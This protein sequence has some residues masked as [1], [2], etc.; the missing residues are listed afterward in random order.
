L[1]RA[2]PLAARL[3]ALATAGDINNA[4]VWLHLDAP[5]R[6]LALERDTLR[7]IAEL[8]SLEVDVYG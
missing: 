5:E 2:S 1:K 6:G 3:A 7:A 4:R 8:G